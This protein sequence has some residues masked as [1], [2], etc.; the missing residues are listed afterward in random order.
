MLL[1]TIASRGSM[2]IVI[3]FKASNTARRDGHIG[4]T[5]SSQVAEVAH[6]VLAAARA[7]S[8][9]YQVLA[10]A[11]PLLALCRDRY[12]FTVMQDGLPS[13]PGAL[14]DALV[15]LLRGLEGV[16]A[17]LGGRRVFP[18][19]GVYFGRPCLEW[20]EDG[21]GGKSGLAVPAE[22]DADELAVFIRPRLRRANC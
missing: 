22:I 21:S 20:F 8:D 11:A 19:F 1:T 7:S 3:P 5:A 9:C 15:T 2:G 14:A 13:T 6:P 10:A 17:D 16:E 18:G 4:S 12:G